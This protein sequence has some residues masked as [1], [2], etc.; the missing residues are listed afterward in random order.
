MLKILGFIRFTVFTI[1]VANKAHFKL[2]IWK[3]IVMQNNRAIQ[4]LLGCSK[5]FVHSW[6]INLVGSWQEKTTLDKN[7]SSVIERCWMGFDGKWLN[8][9][10]NAGIWSKYHF[11]NWFDGQNRMTAK[12]RVK[13]VMLKPWT[14]FETSDTPLKQE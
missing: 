11:W 1:S 12:Q 4:A 5:P 3:T 2:Y 9:L 10:Q 13:D 7:K 6:L 14:G 8:L